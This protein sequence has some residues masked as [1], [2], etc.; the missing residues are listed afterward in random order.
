MPFFILLLGSLW[1][2]DLW[3]AE[4]SK[5][6]LSGDCHLSLMPSENSFNFLFELCWKQ[7]LSN[8]LLCMFA[9]IN[10]NDVISSKYL[11]LA[12]F[13]H[14]NVSSWVNSSVSRVLVSLFDEV[15]G[16]HGAWFLSEITCHLNW[17]WWVIDNMSM[18]SE[19]FWHLYRSPTISW[20][21]ARS[22]FFLK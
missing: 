12:L 18:D 16:V 19:G 4:N 3:L 14:G 7:L 5:H 8:C 13:D 22:H 21:C 15:D 2:E 11:E 20:S 10:I 6:L 1:L 17:S 9:E